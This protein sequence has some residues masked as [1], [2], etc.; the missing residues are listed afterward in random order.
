[1]DSS[2][3]IIL[4][5]K[6]S[7]PK[8]D[9]SP[10]KHHQTQDFYRD[11]PSG[12]VRNNLCMCN[13]NQT[14]TC[15]KWQLTSVGDTLVQVQYKTCAPQ[16]S[17]RKQLHPILSF[18][19]ERRLC[20]THLDHKLSY[21]QTRKLTFSVATFSWNFQLSIFYLVKDYL[22]YLLVCQQILQ[23]PHPGKPK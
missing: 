20:K 7:P 22:P 3:H 12:R 6:T 8:P 23:S 17:L 5:N 11:L 19:V 1:M 15:K 21:T 9:T 4:Q 16:V 14:T 2:L 13:G 18:K 10:K